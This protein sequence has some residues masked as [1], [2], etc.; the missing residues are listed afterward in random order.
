MAST[1]YVYGL[2]GGAGTG[3]DWANAFT[4]MTAA[5]AASTAGGG[6]LFYLAS[7]HSETTAGAVTLTF[8]GVIANPDRVISVNRAGTVPPVAADIANGS[9]LIATSGNNALAVQGC[10]VIVGG[11]TAGATAL[12]FSA[13]SG[14]NIP[15]LRISN[16]VTADRIYIENANLITGGTSAGQ[17]TYVGA[18]GTINSVVDLVGVGFKCNH[19]TSNISFQMVARLR[20]C[21]HYGSTSGGTSPTSIFIPNQATRGY[22]VVIDGFDASNCAAAVNL[23]AGGAVT[24]RGRFVMRNTKLPASWSGLPLSTAFTVAGPRTEFYNFDDD[25][26]SNNALYIGDAFGTVTNENT[27]VRTS[28]ATDGTVP[29][30]WKMVSTAS[31]S[32]PASPLTSPD[33]FL[34]NN[35]VTGNVT[36]SV[37]IIH[38]GVGA[39]TAG[40][41][42]NNEI[43]LE[44]DSLNASTSPLGTVSDSK[45]ATILTAATDIATSSNAWTSS[46]ATPVK[47][48]LS[49]TIAPRMAGMLILR[50][51][52]A[53]AS[54]TVYVDPKVV[55][56]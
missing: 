4:T 43:W 25:S 36:L 27:I 39:G 41:F 9:A 12:S 22:D 49:V 16:N 45:P 7:D 11:A 17:A 46:P 15:D 5:I 14:A 13:G 2:A 54:K 50:V 32:F 33:L 55:V 48:T 52:L 34:R 21:F 1:F 31:S 37:D 20:N 3:A 53:K 47:Q 44:V 19:A 42:Q 24:N 10:V 35:T 18:N 28:G 56:S 29:F 40:A 8:K 6:N 30:S 26:A 51:C 23:V 38:S